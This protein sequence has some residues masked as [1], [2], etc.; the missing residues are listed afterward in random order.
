[1]K[2][3]H[4]PAFIMLLAGAISCIASVVRQDSL[5]QMIKTL[6]IVLVCF[7]VFGI[8]IRKVM[9]KTINDV[10]AKKEDETPSESEEVEELDSEVEESDEE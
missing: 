3:R 5:D 2:T 9:D 1:M 6:I 7:G 4:I 10:F 8:I